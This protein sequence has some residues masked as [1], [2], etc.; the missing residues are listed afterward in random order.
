MVSNAGGYFAPPFQG[1]CGVTQVDPLYSMFLNVVVD[2]VIRH[3]VKVVAPT[4]V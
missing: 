1:Y 4:E 2:A 3:W